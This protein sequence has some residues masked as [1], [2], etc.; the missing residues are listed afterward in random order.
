M[1]IFNKNYTKKYIEYYDD[2]TKSEV[3][4]KC[5]YAKVKADISCFQGV[6]IMVTIVGI[7]FAVLISAT[8]EQINASYAV[9]ETIVTKLDG[10]STPEAIIL[11]R[12]NI[13]TLNYESVDE[14]DIDT[15][16]IIL[17][18]MELKKVKEYDIIIIKMLV[19]GLLYLLGL[20]II[21]HFFSLMELKKSVIEIILQEKK[22]FNNET[23][24]SRHLPDTLLFKRHL[25][26]KK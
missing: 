9:P 8:I 7:I 19:I 12:L 20:I 24:T 23:N 6:A 2:Y 14:K 10:I 22:I 17:M 13:N 1:N 5:E 3:D 16:I 25:R 18:G 21:I 4:L 15:Q 26:Y 11:K